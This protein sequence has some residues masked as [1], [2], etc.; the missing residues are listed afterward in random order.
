MTVRG[1]A[2]KPSKAG[3]KHSMSGASSS[4][5]WL[6]SAPGGEHLVSAG[7]HDRIQVGILGQGLCGRQLG[8]PLGRE[9]VH[10]GG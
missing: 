9:G 1:M 7:E 10:L 6:I 8:Q 4:N 2:A 5:S 3:R